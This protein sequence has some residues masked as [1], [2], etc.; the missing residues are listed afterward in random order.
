MRKRI[1]L[2]QVEKAVAWSRAAGLTVK[3][4]YM[5][6]IPG[7]THASLQKTEQ[8]LLWLPLDDILLEYFTPFPG[9]ELY[10]QL[11]AQDEDLPDW[12]DLNTF[13]L[14]YVPQGLDPHTL[15][16]AY[17][18]ILKKFYLRPRIIWSYSRRFA[19]PFKMMA[20]ARTFFKFM[21]SG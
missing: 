13:E 18:R 11:L 16:T 9:S 5:I 19:N 1:S 7:E 17:K 6:G 10:D 21:R 8:H 3:G 14:A 20:L 15:K 4:Y 12:S 2:T